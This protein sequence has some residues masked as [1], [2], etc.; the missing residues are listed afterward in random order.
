[1]VGRLL[2]EIAQRVDI[3]WYYRKNKLYEIVNTEERLDYHCKKMWEADLI[4]FDTETTGVKICSLPW[5]SQGK[6]HCV[7]LCLSYETNQGIYIPLDH[8]EFPNMDMKSVVKKVFPILETK[9][10][11]THNGIFDYKVMYDMGCKINIVH[12]SMIL[13]FNIYSKL[14]KGSKALKNITRLLYG[15][16]TIEFEDIFESADDY[17][18]F[19]YI[20]EEVCKIYACADADYTRQ[21]VI[22]NFGFLDS[23]QRVAYMRDVSFIGMIAISEYHGK[24][25]DVTTLP[26]C[27]L[28]CKE[29]I[30]NLEDMLFNYVGWKTTGNLDV[31]YR[32]KTTSNEELVKVFFD[33]LKYEP[34]HLKNR[35]KLTVDKFVRKRLKQRNTVDVDF[36]MKSKYPEGLVNLLADDPNDESQKL[37]SFEEVKQKECIPAFILD[38]LKKQQKQLTAFFNKIVTESDSSIGIY[39]SGI[40]MTNTETARLVDFLQTLDGGL[41]YLIAVPDRKKQYMYVFDFS[42][43][44][45]RVMAALAKMTD[46]CN[47]LDNTHTDF[48][49]E[50]AA[51]IKNTLPE[52]IDDKT[53]KMYKPV[54][55]GIAYGMAAQGLI[56]SIFGVGLSDEEEK[57]CLKQVEQMLSDWERAMKE[58]MLMLNAY[59]DIACTPRPYNHITVTSTVKNPS[60]IHTPEGRVRV[61]DLKDESKPVISKIRRMAGNTPI[62]SLAR[63]IYL[64]A[65]KS[66]YDTLVREGLTDIK[67][68]NPD[69]MSGYS[70]VS[71]VTINGYVHDEIFGFVDNDINP[72]YMYYLIRKN[73]MRKYEGHPYYYCGISICN[74]WYEGKYGDY[75]APVDFVDAMMTS[76]KF[77]TPRENW[78]EYVAAQMTNWINEDSIKYIEKLAGSELTEHK[79]LRV[80]KILSKWKDY[81]YKKKIKEFGYAVTKVLI[82]KEKDKKD[83]N[84][85]VINKLIGILCYY[86][87]GQIRVI[88]EA[89]GLDKVVTSSQVKAEKEQTGR[90]EDLFEK[91]TTTY[92]VENYDEDAYGEVVF[93]SDEEEPEEEPEE[94]NLEQNAKLLETFLFK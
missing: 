23:R 92:S 14:A 32:F 52:L 22:D 48:H 2:Q 72:Y 54:N 29:N 51:L 69:S 46:L 13:I 12:D 33:L 87:Y 53:R 75:E 30:Q 10:L 9:S 74:T 84:V 5:G 58:I 67:I 28:K 82:S 17:T 50:C 91:F 68:E 20:C 38:S 71:K 89:Y 18:K 39:Y 66:F 35:E 26:D 8:T 16:E 85:K 73:C 3:S 88:W 43:I 47:K 15:D 4:G 25:I 62:Q 80:D 31:R 1:M 21:I 76:E 44:E 19:R 78:P 6:D 49:V 60:Y 24:P 42:Q 59:R 94:V 65:I 45:Y 93:S 7:G 64:I 57:K 36:F 81:Y 83:E 70:Y 11:V 34:V 90:E 86:K 55:F 40:S 63:T 41:K 56:S 79:I 27:V 61:F 77:T 37:V